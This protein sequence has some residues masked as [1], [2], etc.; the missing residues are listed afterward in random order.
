MLDIGKRQ[1]IEDP[2]VHDIFR[3]DKRDLLSFVIPEI[4]V[5]SSGGHE[6]HFNAEDIGDWFGLREEL[7][8]FGGLSGDWDWDWVGRH[9]PPEEYCEF[10]F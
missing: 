5:D 9:F 3:V 7:D 8:E 2:L 10:A 1:H 4:P 6:V